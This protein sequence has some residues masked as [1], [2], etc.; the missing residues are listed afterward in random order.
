[1]SQ[2]KIYIIFL[3]TV[4][5]SGSAVA[6]ER[7]ECK[8]PTTG[9]NIE[10]IVGGNVA[11]PSDFPWQVEIKGSQ[12]GLCGGSL[13]GEKYVLTAAHCVSDSTILN[14]EISQGSYITAALVDPDGKAEGDQRMV[15]SV[16]IH[17]G[18]DPEAMGQPYDIAVLEL[19]ERFS[20]G[21]GGLVTLATERSDILYSQPNICSTVTGWGT[22]EPGGNTSQY[23]KQTFVPIISN[24]A[25]SNFYPEENINE[26]HLCA[27]YE[28]GGADSCQG[29][30]G[31]PLVIRGGPTGLLQVGIVSWGYGCAEAG[32]PGVYQRV[33]IHRDWIDETIY[34]IENN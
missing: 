4:T 6:Q 2:N 34:D 26:Q 25:C 31:G 30:S 8:D 28:Q 27:G 29:D 15:E 13:I 14:G 11:D 33:G 17:P 23:L 16:H 12:I 10:R 5:M 24:D 9:R 1:M 18:Y 22:T 20:V 32:R 3:T 21:M 7:F 19:E